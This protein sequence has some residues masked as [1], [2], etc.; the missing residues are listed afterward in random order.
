MNMPR[1][2]RTL[3]ISFC[4]FWLSTAI[5]H[6]QT[7]MEPDVWQSVIAELEAGKTS[8]LDAAGTV[9]G[10]RDPLPP[11]DE[12]FARGVWKEVEAEPKHWVGERQAPAFG[13]RDAPLILELSND[14]DIP[15]LRL[16][17]AMPESWEMTD[18]FAIGPGTLLDQMALDPQVAPY[19]IFTT[20]D[21]N[22]TTL[23]E[24][25]R[26]GLNFSSSF[27][28]SQELGAILSGSLP[29]YN[30]DTVTGA[31]WMRNGELSF[32]LV[33]GALD[34]PVIDELPLPGVLV[35]LRS[36]IGAD[37]TR[38]T[39][40]HFE[41]QPIPGTDDA[42]LSGELVDLES[43]ILPLSTPLTASTF[44]PGA[45]ASAFGVSNSDEFPLPSIGSLRLDGWDG[46][47]PRALTLEVNL[48]TG[49]IAGVRLDLNAPALSNT[50]L[51]PDLAELRDLTLGLLVR[52]PLNKRERVAGLVLDS[53]LRLGGVALQARFVAPGQVLL[54]SLKPSADLTLASLADAIGLDMAGLPSLSI[55]T[56][57]AAFPVKSPQ[58]FTID[59]ALEGGLTLPDSSLSISRPVLRIDR[60]SPGVTGMTV[61]G[62]V[63]IGGTSV[64]VS[65]SRVAAND[66][67]LEGL[68][69]SLALGDIAS[70][71]GAELPDGLNDISL[72]DGKLRFQSADRQLSIDAEATGDIRADIPTEFSDISARIA[73]GQISIEIAPGDI[74]I[75]AQTQTRL[76]GIPD[77]I[78]RP[79]GDAGPVLFPTS[80]RDWQ[81]TF[82]RSARK[83]SF[84][85]RTSRFLEQPIIADLGQLSGNPDAARLGTIWADV[86]EVEIDL[87][88]RR[89]IRA[90][91]AFAIDHRINRLFG[92]DDSGAPSR[93]LLRGFSTSDA[94]RD[95]ATPIALSLSNRG[96]SARLLASPFVGPQPDDKGLYAFDFGEFGALQTALPEFSLGGDGW[97]GSGLLA[98]T[99][100]LALPLSAVKTTLA[101]AG[102]GPISGLL[103]DRI[104][105]RDVRI[106]ENNRLDLSG[107]RDLIYRATA[108]A[109]APDLGRTI[110]YYL[111]LLA[112]S[113]HRILERTPGNL[114]DY[115]AIKVPDFIAFSI[116]AAPSGRI[117]L[118]LSTATRRGER[119]NPIQMLFPTFG[120]LGPQL[121]GVKLH[122]ASVAV[123]GASASLQLAVDAVIDNFDLL[124]MAGCLAV[125]TLAD[126]KSCKTYTNQIVL[127]QVTALWPAG[128][129][130]PIPM[131]FDE[132]GLKYRG[133]E[134]FSAST[135]WSLPRPPESLLIDFVRFARE[136][137]F[138]LDPDK[139]GPT[140][141]GTIT[142]GPNFVKMPD[143]LG[144]SVLGSRRGLPRLKAWS[145]SAHLLNAL[146]FGDVRELLQALPAR[147]RATRLTGE[148]GPL[149]GE[150]NAALLTVRERAQLGY[151]PLPPGFEGKIGLTLNGSSN[152]AGLFNGTSQFAVA[153]DKDVGIG[154]MVD[155]EGN[156]ANHFMIGIE[157]LLRGGAEDQEI[158]GFV[159]LGLKNG[160]RIRTKA[161]ILVKD[162]AM[163]AALSMAVA[164][165]LSLEG[166]WRLQA[167]PPA[168]TVNGEME[169]G[170]FGYTISSSASAD[171]NTSRLKLSTNRRISLLATEGKLEVEV[172]FKTSGT[173]KGTLFV[174]ID[175]QEAS[176]FTSK[177][178]AALRDLEQDVSDAQSKVDKARTDFA[179]KAEDIRKI[180]KAFSS[181]TLE[182]TKE[183]FAERV[184]TDCKVAFPV[185]DWGPLGDGNSAIRGT[186]AFLGK[187]LS[188]A[189]LD[190]LK[191]LI[192]V[193][194]VDP[195]DLEEDLGEP[196][197]EAIDAVLNFR[198]APRI[199]IPGH[200]TLEIFSL[201]AR[202]LM[203]DADEMRLVTAKNII[204]D[205]PRLLALQGQAE[206]ALGASSEV[207]A[208]TRDALGITRRGFPELRSITLATGLSQR[209][210]WVR[211]SAKMRVNR[212]IET[213]GIWFNLQNPLSSIG[214]LAKTLVKNAGK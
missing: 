169:W 129:P 49:N 212:R 106:V 69:E 88:V 171:V 149:T 66:W 9:C 14:P 186:C 24:T 37:N 77:G 164:N 150:F 156:I 170:V 43:H 117:G 70:L 189:A 158:D 208:V 116:N 132:L 153:L 154:T 185:W 22:D 152:I 20:E 25:L 29:A 203:T 21:Y 123:S 94:A 194:I 28:A 41:S 127:D 104:P 187:R 19:F 34:I 190:G 10:W 38:H 53:D 60:A 98:V 52:S 143:F 214:E 59:I 112:G 113:S 101:G 159:E 135:L 11:K 96:V 199:W 91:L 195:D 151:D 124:S 201:K 46:L 191:G 184:D 35:S 114:N 1:L 105:L 128:S 168:M 56:L 193:I 121:T 167:D 23:G 206:A 177:V 90:N 68:F 44:D 42:V 61:S 139:S 75:E 72:K 183:Q 180:L 134:G 211:A 161:R 8:P 108:S 54:A 65:A 30:F 97:S 207:L 163:S 39:R 162:K 73:L 79:F 58:R 196:L 142:V 87:G 182:N 67:H 205:L 200:G 103:P 144:G 17:A 45:I 202:D 125:G 13:A 107:L 7:R 210:T 27:V 155:I 126:G 92:V 50:V 204:S 84:F 99:R 102:L 85:L 120:V 32:D 178:R 55:A 89:E 18:T 57:E 157:G 63:Q 198:I 83:N 2:L 100:P 81:L 209:S 173:A 3:A 138:R 74:D 131:F 82:Q 76:M 86:S 36:D 175:H 31:V 12:A 47:S 62:D 71:T 64:A 197:V 111:G 140:G 4:L 5:I 16:Y 15:C 192:S 160:P 133:W 148:L 110:D 6:A 174:G 213:L 95:Q 141:G 179:G 172:P 40:L 166:Q 93:A 136:P 118:D 176:E 181:D 115:F 145:T 119:Q 109:G 78:S 26:S 147:H 51:I 80:P 165:N 130:L 122:G 188:G 48:F 137:G 146:K 33:V